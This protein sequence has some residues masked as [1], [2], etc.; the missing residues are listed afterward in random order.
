M[1]GRAFVDRPST[2]KFYC[3]GCRAV[4][5]DGRSARAL[6]IYRRPIWIG[7]LLLL[8]SLTFG[9]GTVRWRYLGLFLALHILS[10]RHEAQL[11]FHLRSPPISRPF[12]FAKL[13]FTA[14]KRPLLCPLLLYSISYHSFG[15]R[16]SFF[17][18]WRR[19]WA[20]RRRRL[21]R[22]IRDSF[23]R[24][25]AYSHRADGHTGKNKIKK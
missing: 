15:L 6:I 20:L 2:R 24:S 14:K 17:P 7:F 21:H 9:I 25:P 11:D 19:R 1:E 12:F 18:P 10:C 5:T 3:P 13:L 23:P 16:S 8:Q 22:L 4:E